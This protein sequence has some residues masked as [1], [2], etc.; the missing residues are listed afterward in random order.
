MS[1][2]RPTPEEERW[3]A[4]GGRLRG[5]IPPAAVQQ[6]AGGWRSTGPFARVALFVL[7]VVAAGLTFAVLGIGSEDTL[8][9]AGLVAA[10]AAEWLITSRRFHASGIEEG[11]CAAGCL[12]IAVWA[13]DKTGP[14][15]SDS[16]AD[17]FWI[18]IV[19]AMA[20]AGLRLL[21]PFLTTLAALAL[22]NWFGSTGVARAI[23]GPAG[24]GTAAFVVAC[25]GAAA[26]L[27]A[28]AREF[29]R[30]SYDRM[31]D[32][33]VIALPLFA[34]D[35]QASSVA[36][37]TATGAHPGAGVPA[38]NIALLLALGVASLA[39]G[40]R[41]RRHAPVIAFLACLACLAVEWLRAAHGPAEYWI[42]LYGVIAMAV[43]GAV[44]RHLRR[45]RRGI[46]SARLSDREG[47]LDLLQT[48]GAAVLAQRP[49][50]PSSAGDSEPRPHEGRFGGGGASGNF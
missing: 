8:L 19:A 6:R 34:Y 42:V 38:I 44:D 17:R 1:R 25:A 15:F 27:L 4:A 11:L 35:W 12:M 28:G 41:R 43:A 23:G 40:L 46:T 31:L 14:L 30:P 20:A 3:L 39:S 9:A 36:I 47:P 16:G 33:L 32:G 26:A 21:N 2:W 29:R 24:G 18:A 49:G 45:P 37:A 22:V 10:G 5:A 48:I 50:A 7:G 13:M